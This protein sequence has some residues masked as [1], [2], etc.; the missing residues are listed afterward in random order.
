MWEAYH[1]HLQVV[2]EAASAEFLLWGLIY[3]TEENCETKSLAAV[4]SVALD[5]KLVAYSNAASSPEKKKKKQPQSK[6]GSMLKS[7]AV[8]NV[9]VC[10]D[11]KN[12]L[13]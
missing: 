1:G 13:T 2:T 9:T 4:S 6:K 3:V 7:G 11:Q 8:P 5:W 10:L 12:S